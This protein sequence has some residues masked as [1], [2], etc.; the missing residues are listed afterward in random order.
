MRNQVLRALA[1][2]SFLFALP[3]VAATIPRATISLSDAPVAGEALVVTWRLE[4]DSALAAS[5]EL[6]LPPSAR[7]LSGSTTWSGMLAPNQPV[8]LRVVASIGRRGKSVAAVRLRELGG[9]RVRETLARHDFA[10]G[11]RRVSRDVPHKT[12]AARAIAKGGHPRVESALFSAEQVVRLAGRVV[13]APM[14]IGRVEIAAGGT[15]IAYLHFAANS[16]PEAVLLRMNESHGVVLSKRRGR[17]AR[18]TM[19]ILQI[20]AL[21]DAYPEVA[22][23]TGPKP[24]KPNATAGQGVTRTGAYSHH[25]RSLTGAN[26]RVAVIDLG[27]LHHDLS[28]SSGDL[29][30]NVIKIDC[31]GGCATTTFPDEDEDHG[32]AVAEIVHEMAPGAQLYLI[33]IFDELDLMDAVDYA[34]ANDIDVINHSVGW[35][36]Y[37][38]YDGACWEDEL[39]EPSP[40]CAADAAIDAGILWVNSAGN[41]ATDHYGATFTDAN[42][43]GYHD[44]DVTFQAFAGNDI[45]VFLTW[46][47]WPTSANDYDFELYDPSNVRVAQSIDWQ[48]G[49]EPPREGIGHIAATTG[50]YRL[51]IYRYDADVLPRFHIHSFTQSLSPS[52]AATSITNPADASWVVSV[53]AIDQ[54]EY[55]TAEEP[56]FYSS[57]GPTSDGVLAPVISAPDAVSNRTYTTFYGTS[58]SSPHVAGAAALLAGANPAWTWLDL[59]DELTETAIDMGNPGDD[60]DF[61]SGRLNLCLAPA[62]PVLSGA[63]SGNVGSPYVISWT[64]TSPTSAYELQEATNAE[65]TAPSWFAAI[66]PT[67]QLTRQQAGTYYYRVRA[68][69]TCN[70]QPY[71]SAWSNVRQVVVAGACVTL[72]ISGAGGGT[73]AVLTGPNCSGNF[74]SGSA[75]TIEAIP[76]AGF[77]FSS[78]S[79]GSGSFASTTAAVTTFT[80][81]G[82]STV[83]A[84][85]VAVDSV[86]KRGDLDNDRISD[87]VWRHSQTGSN[88]L[89]KITAQRVTASPLPA[90]TD[91]NWAIVA[92]GDLNGDGIA[93]LIYR[94]AVTGQNYVWLMN[95]TTATPLALETVSDQ[96]W[97]IVGAGDLNGDGR[98]DLLWRNISTGSNYLW[99]MNG[100]ASTP[101]ALPAVPADWTFGGVGDTNLDNRADIIWRN[102]A[103]GSTYIWLMDGATVT[104]SARL[105]AT[106]DSSWQIAGAGDFNGDRRMDL[107]WRRSDGQNYLWFLNGTSTP[108]AAPLPTVA[109]TTWQALAFGDFDGD[110]RYDIIWRHAGSGSVYEWLLD[111]GTVKLN[112]ALPTVSD[113]GWRIATPR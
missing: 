95:G 109:D 53:G 67:F 56:E 46:D 68:L 61:G 16:D 39:L 45:V 80:I 5:A 59:Y 84:N 50:T 73:V 75:V 40:V 17:Y 66:G 3:A 31:N 33:K 14:K 21:A 98:D 43:N 70:G 15:T 48:L 79:G 110:G 19:P 22:R 29:P 41:S 26:T 78:W 93:D 51:R 90:V 65:F 89:W 52:T 111:G 38:F 37:N 57:R 94:H 1:L 54:S 82:N 113:L 20:T 74:S 2:V 112:I 108:S 23:I 55:T 35:V 91:V 107:M 77:V 36:N 42:A 62:A 11:A 105:A 64:L 69:D 47:D 99:L 60:N 49:D 32:T 88:Y 100:A 34:E 25:T 4:T 83:T 85:F 30:A 58:A 28:I 104:T 72:S 97:R 13:D 87:I 18:V 76:S 9:R 63:T 24:R 86:R 103:L 10:V 27:F 8:E 106:A 12:S 44:T 92:T 96:A 6:I 71:T 101:L 7:V 81:T 102:G